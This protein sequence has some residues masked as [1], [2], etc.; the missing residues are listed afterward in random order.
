MQAQQVNVCMHDTK[1][2]RT[3]SDTTKIVCVVHVYRNTLN[4]YKLVVDLHR[5]KEGKEAK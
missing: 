3:Q 1:T 4:D 5:L 2:Q